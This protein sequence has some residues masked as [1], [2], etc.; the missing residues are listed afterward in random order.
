MNWRSN[1]YIRLMRLDK[2]IGTFLL[3]WPTLWALWFATKGQ[4]DPFILLVFVTGV[5]L[6]RAAGCVINDFAD[7]K[8][9]GKV[10]RTENRPLV[11]GEVSSKQALALFFGLITLAFALVLTLDWNTVALS[12]VAL[13]LAAI[14]PF[15]K[16]YT[17]LPQVFLGAAFGWA[18][19]MVY[20]ASTGAIPIEAW[21]LF[22]ANMLWVLSY[23][24]MYAM[25]D[26]EDDIKAGIKSTAVLFGK[27]TPF[28][29][30]LFQVFFIVLMFQIGLMTF[31]GM[32]YYIAI[33]IAL[34]LGL[35]Q[36]KLIQVGQR[37]LYF[38]A[39]LN[40]NLLGFIIFMGI[41]I[42]Y[43]VFTHV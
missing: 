34:F 26:H 25:V 12:V 42:N 7:R 28:W 4:P 10:K 21:L 5:F 1:P 9:D 32:Y 18:I 14:Y 37:E 35:Y 29:L 2:P 40:N 15:M 3:L 20:M 6:M 17:H 22:V 31:Q 30:S 33:V 36:Q 16:R 11:T 38:K 41:F 24:T 39:F 27:F 23:D 13:I 8:V 19:P 43:A